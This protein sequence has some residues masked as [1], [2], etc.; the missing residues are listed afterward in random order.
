MTRPLTLPAGPWEVEGATDHEERV[1][2]L[3]ATPD[4]APD[5]GDVDDPCD[6]GPAEYLGPVEM[7]APSTLA[8]TPTLSIFII[9]P[10]CFKGK[11]SSLVKDII[12]HWIRFRSVSHSQ[13]SRGH[14]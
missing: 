14:F 10:S 9:G 12:F 7:Q 2:A 13:R 4:E 3:L 11:G 1:D 5:E 6:G 8:P